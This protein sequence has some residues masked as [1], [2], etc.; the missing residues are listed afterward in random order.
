M[1]LGV[2][3]P[4]L[5]GCLRSTSSI[6][7]GHKQKIRQVLARAS[8]KRSTSKNKNTHTNERIQAE[9]E[10]LFVIPLSP[11]APVSYGDTFRNRVGFRKIDDP[12]TDFG[13]VVYHED[14]ASHDLQE[15]TQVTYKLGSMEVYGTD[16]V[17]SISL[18]YLVPLEVLGLFEL[19]PDFAE[20]GK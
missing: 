10:P 12:S 4:K 6:T 11:R 5:E 2:T 19:G 18:V 14:T 13:V 20:P 9:E 7:Y 1:V 15:T 3:S 16:S 17:L 8:F